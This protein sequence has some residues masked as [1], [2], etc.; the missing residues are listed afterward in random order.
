[1]SSSPRECVFAVVRYDSLLHTNRRPT[2][3]T[4]GAVAPPGSYAV[5]CNTLSA[6][7][8]S[9]ALPTPVDR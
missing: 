4:T 5:L 9:T 8:E 2:P 3:P 1:M 7:L 6:P